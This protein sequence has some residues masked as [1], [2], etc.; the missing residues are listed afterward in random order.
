MSNSLKNR[1]NKGVLDLKPYEPGKPIE[2]TEKELGLENIVKLAS[3]ENPIG[4]IPKAHEV[5]SALTDLNRYPD[6]NAS[7]FKE[8]VASSFDV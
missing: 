8:K 7:A 1:V 5:V 3:N 4:M 2:E 6:G